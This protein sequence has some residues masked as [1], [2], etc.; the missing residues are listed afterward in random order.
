MRSP[1]VAYSR[2]VCLH[3]NALNK[4]SLMT[5][6]R[7]V[8]LSAFT[9]ALAGMTRATTRGFLPIEEATRDVAP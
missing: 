3:A 4:E 2:F 6:S 5:P 7:R 9:T 8:V 1:Y